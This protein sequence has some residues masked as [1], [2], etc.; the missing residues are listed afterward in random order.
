MTDLVTRIKEASRALYFEPFN[1]DCRKEFVAVCEGA[2]ANYLFTDFDGWI[3]RRFRYGPN[4]IISVEIN[5]RIFRE[6]EISLLKINNKNHFLGEIQYNLSDHK[7]RYINF[8]GIERTEEE[9]NHYKRVL[10][11]AATSWRSPDEGQQFLAEQLLAATSKYFLPKE[12]KGGTANYKDR[13]C[14]L[15]VSEREVPTNSSIEEANVEIAIDAK[16]DGEHYQVVITGKACDKKPI[17][18]SNKFEIKKIE[19]TSPL[20]KIEVY[21]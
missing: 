12:S 1:R 13:R 14:T 16:V 2:T 21:L 9:I 11:N 18:K 19:V 7:D 20:P 17:L 10:K 6:P 8:N 3:R 4:T 5:K 15:F